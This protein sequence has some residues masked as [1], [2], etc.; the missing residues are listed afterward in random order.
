MGNWGCFEFIVAFFALLIGLLPVLFGWEICKRLGLP[1]WLALLNIVSGLGTFLFLGIL[2]WIE[3][4]PPN[5]K[6]P[7]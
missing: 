2:S 6:R 7:L 5:D 4:P 1:R 3:W